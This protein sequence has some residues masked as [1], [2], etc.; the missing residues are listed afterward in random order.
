MMEVMVGGEDN[1]W[2]RKIITI[3][4]QTTMN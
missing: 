3:L 1:Y 4:K 2:F